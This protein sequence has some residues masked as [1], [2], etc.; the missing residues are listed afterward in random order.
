MLI[1]KTTRT[2]GRRRRWTAKTITALTT[3]AAIAARTETKLSNSR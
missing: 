2:L 3:E 1:R